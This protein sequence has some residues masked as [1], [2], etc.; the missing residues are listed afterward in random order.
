MFCFKMS[1]ELEKKPGRTRLTTS[2]SWRSNDLDLA[3]RIASKKGLSLSAW[4]RTLIL[5]EFEK[6]K[7]F[8]SHSSNQ[9]VRDAA[10]IIFESAEKEGGIENLSFKLMTEELRDLTGQEIIEASDLA[11]KALDASND[12]NIQD[13]A[14]LHETYDNDLNNKT[15]S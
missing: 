9:K 3:K 13:P 4:I 7:I 6:E 14:I 10:K 2:I 15:G 1:D 11:K 5:N 12:M 8:L